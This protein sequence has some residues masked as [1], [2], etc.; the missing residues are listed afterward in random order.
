MGSHDL[1]I[2]RKGLMQR[3]L[4]QSLQHDELPPYG[5]D[6]PDAQECFKKLT[7]T[8]GKKV[9]LGKLPRPLG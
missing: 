1:E 2:T 6:L 9:R 5:R 4:F 3:R 8:R 7:R